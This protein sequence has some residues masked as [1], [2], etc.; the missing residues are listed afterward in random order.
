MTRGDPSQVASQADQWGTAFP[1]FLKSQTPDPVWRDFR[2]EAFRSFQ[3]Q[4]LPH[5][6]QEDWRHTPLQALRDLGPFQPISASDGSLAALENLPVAHPEWPQAVFIDG[7]LDRERSSLPASSVGI[8]IVDLEQALE[9]AST[10]ETLLGRIGKLADPRTDALTALSSAFMQGGSLVR[11]REGCVVDQPIHLVFMWTEKGTLRCPRILVLAEPASQATALVEHISHE[12]HASLVN[13][14]SEIFIEDGAHLEWLPVQHL[15][16]SALHVSNLQAQIA[17]SGRLGLHLLSLS[18]HFIRNNIGVDLIAPNA[19]VELNS[20]FLAGEGQL[21]DHHTE[22]RHKAPHARS[23]QI[24]KAVLAGNARGV[25]RGLIHVD[26]DTQKTESSLSSSSLLLSKRARIDSEPQLKI[27]TDDVTC[28]HGST[29]GQLDEEALFYL[30]TRGIGS[31]HARQILTRA[32][33]EEICRRLPSDH[34]RN[35]VS[36]LV[37]TELRALNSISAEVPG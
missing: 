19:Q 15:A 13:S 30:R 3:Q 12:S 37:S 18:G 7:K 11:I 23:Q 2:E 5:T 36:S 33:T 24:H 14:V 26:P 22:I 16:P 4:G 35:F 20:L 6:R 21:A 9:D 10:R 25:F 8:E 31:E 32:F 27:F 17:Q 34:L 28:S 1:D 29:V